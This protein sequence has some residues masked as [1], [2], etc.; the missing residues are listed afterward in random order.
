[1]GEEMCREPRFP[2]TDHISQAPESSTKG[3]NISESVTD[4][5]KGNR[6]H[7]LPA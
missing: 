3:S 1:M 7:E 2:N 6:H 5:R 4:P